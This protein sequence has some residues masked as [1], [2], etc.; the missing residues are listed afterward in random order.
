[1]G[2][3]LKIGLIVGGVILAALVIVPLVAGM[4]T[5]W[6]ACRAEMFEHGMMGPWMMTGLGG[7]SMMGIIW[8]GIV[9]LIV[10]LVV[11]LARGS[12]PMSSSHDGGDVKVLEIL[13]TRYV[14]GEIDKA[15]YEEKLKDLQ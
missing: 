5:G 8:L 13:K 14:H 2:R 9:G 10:W 12:H 1:M 4:S 15:E 6:E 7:W 3:N 11:S